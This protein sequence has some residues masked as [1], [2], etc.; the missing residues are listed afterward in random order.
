MKIA[1]IYCEDIS[2][3]LGYVIT[4]LKSRGHDVRLFFSPR[5]FDR[6]YVR[7][8]LLARLLNLD[9][10]I[11]HKVEQ[12]N[13]DM[14]L[15]SPVT[16]HYTWNLKIAKRVKKIL[17]HT[18]IIFGGIHST[19]VPDEVKS[20]DFIDEVIVG[21]GVEH[22]EGVFDPD[23]F[24]PDRDIFFKELPSYHRKYQLF[25]TS[26]GCPFACSYCA[27]EEL[28]KHYKR[29]LI[30]RSVEGCIEELKRLKEKGMRYVLFVDD[31]FTIDS[32]WLRDFCRRYIDDISLPFCCFGHPKFLSEE[33]IKTLSQMG[34]EMVWIGIQTASEQL[35]KDIL[36]R[37]ET[38]EEIKVACALIKK[39][40][41]K[42][43]IDHIF[44]LPYE[45]EMTND[46]SV[47]FYEELKPDVVNCYELL[48]FPKAKIIEHAIK[49]GYI[50]LPDVPKIE[51][52]EML[53]YHTGNRGNFFYDIYHKPM[54]TIPLG[55]ITWELLPTW[56]VKLIVYIRAGRAFIPIV[57]VQNEVYFT[58]KCLLKK[59]RII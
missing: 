55:N 20:H 19:L 47:A 2:L 34:C 27:N 18:K 7:N 16:A 54:V 17:P 52:G 21:D 50:T 57:M 35:R 51:R 15:F 22:F 12:F 10:Y 40:K 43:M 49:F 41:M 1:C 59:L 24:W 3:G 32:N 14:V 42:L 58:I 8:K 38:N 11:I 26:F 5:Q 28:R 46:F 44:G 37:P 31:I 4:H 23:N 25:M 13:P 48:Y 9:N 39:Y 56:L 53:Q 45:S 29:K 33:V 30:K 6:G 36:N